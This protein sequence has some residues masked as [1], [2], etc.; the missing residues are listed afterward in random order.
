MGASTRICNALG[1]GTARRA[2]VAVAE[3]A[4]RRCRVICIGAGLRPAR[5]PTAAA[6]QQSASAVRS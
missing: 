6:T 3:Q 5:A 2:I 4:A 1:V